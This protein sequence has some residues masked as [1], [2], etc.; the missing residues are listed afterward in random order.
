M[1]SPGDEGGCCKL[2]TLV[3]PSEQTSEVMDLKKETDMFYTYVSKNIQHTDHVTSIQ[4]SPHLSKSFMASKCR[5]LQRNLIAVFSLVM[6]FIPLCLNV[7]NVTN[8]TPKHNCLTFR[9]RTSCILGLTTLQRTLF[10]YLIN[11]YISLYDIC[12]T[13][14]H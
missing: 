6:Q 9:H 12:L 3:I 14:H 11:K 7:N 13:V 4:I 5:T 1:N 8:K 10:I 2:A